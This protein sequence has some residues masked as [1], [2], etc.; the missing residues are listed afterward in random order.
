MAPLMMPVVMLFGIATIGDGGYGYDE[1]EY[2]GF[3][4]DDCVGEFVVVVLTLLC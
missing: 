1:S 3:E 4:D 2:V